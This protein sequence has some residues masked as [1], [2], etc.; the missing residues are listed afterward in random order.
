MNT[1]W[2]AATLFAVTTMPSA[3]YEH[4]SVPLRPSGLR[5]ALHRVHHAKSPRGTVLILHG[6]TIPTLLSAG[7]GLEGGSW[8]DDLAARG[9]DVWGLDFLGYGQSDR[10]PQMVSGDPNAPPLESAAEG[11]DEVLQAMAFI[12]TKTDA[13]LSIVA[14]SWGTLVAG[15]VASRPEAAVR[16]VVLYGALVPPAAPDPSAQM[17]DKPFT[18]VSVDY[19][20]A[21]FGGGVPA[22]RERAIDRATF[23]RWAAAYLASDPSSGSRTPPS[24]RVP[25]GPDADYARVLRG[26]WFPYDPA[27][28]RIPVLLARG[29]WDVVINGADADR[30]MAA[31]T[32]S[33]KKRTVS[34]ADGTHRLH[35]ERNR[36]QL[37]D[38]VALFLAESD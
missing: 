1:I 13:P 32:A 11:A 26:G 4:Y 23:D 37:Y 33:P 36:R 12:R 19:Q 29:T 8:M 25:A 17:P 24:V 7:Y 14:H 38:E 21:G 10:Y 20:W 31:L 15:I 6:S 35:W 16:R 3:Q 5:V 2:I 9:F 34:I 22:G 27:A 18:D 30:F 28:I